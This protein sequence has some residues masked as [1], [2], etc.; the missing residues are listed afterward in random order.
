M[1]GCRYATANARTAAIHQYSKRIIAFSCGYLKPIVGW[2]QS[3]RQFRESNVRRLVAC[4]EYNKTIINN[5]SDA[6][7]GRQDIERFS[8]IF[9][10]HIAC[11]GINFKNAFECNSC[12]GR[13]NKRHCQWNIAEC[14]AICSQNRAN[15]VENYWFVDNTSRCAALNIDCY[16]GIAKVIS[17]SGTFDG[18]L[19]GQCDKCDSRNFNQFDQ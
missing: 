15:F 17:K 2:K 6:C 8:T 10:C 12:D 9:E 5:R 3:N 13:H 16:R 14:I 7:V 4:T 1:L 11:G 19:I 18:S